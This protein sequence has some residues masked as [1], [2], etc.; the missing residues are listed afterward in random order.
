MRTVLV[1]DDEKNIRETL[2]DVLEDEGYNVLLAEDGKQAIDVLKTSRVDVMLLDLWLPKIGGM[3]VLDRVK[4][5]HGDVEI[6]IVSGH[7]TIDTAVKATKIGAFDFIEKPLSLDR[8]LGV[9]D[10][11]VKMSRLKSENVLLKEGNRKKYYMVEGKS[12]A[13]REVEDLVASCAGSNSRVLITGENG[14]GKEVVAR[15]IHDMSIRKGAPFVAV[16]CAAIPDTLI[17][18]EL[19]GYQKGAFTGALEDKKGRFELADTGTIFLDEIA[20]MSLEAQSKVLRVLEDMQFERV[21]GVEP[22]KVD[23]RV[24]AATNKE[25]AK[26][27]KGGR[28]REDLYYRLNVVPI[29]IRPLR[30]RREDIPALIDYYL[31]FF[32]GENNK[33]KKE[34]GED[35]MRFLTQK[36]AWPG[37]IR[38]L[39]NLMERLSILARGKSIGIEDVRNNIPSVRESAMLSGEMG[40]REAG[41]REARESFERN[42]IETTLRENDYNISKAAKVLKIERTNLYK[43]VKKL[44]IEIKR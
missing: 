7:G 23:V 28:F 20:D 38:E 17:E 34:I 29:H 33:K 18:S 32:A 37:N 19:F 16:N 36:Y 42:V 39:K 44:D 26:E 9:V 13:H 24:I 31:E 14:T 5:Q 3:E 12:E 41:L 8:V 11:A 21:G 40:I 25:V 30:E 2:K 6:I 1:V 35:A 22:I 4:R 10:H 27:I 43:L 15:R